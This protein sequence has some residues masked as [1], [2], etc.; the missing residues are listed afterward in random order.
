MEVIL[1]E[2]AEFQLSYFK[3]TNQERI[4]KKIRSLIENII[5]NPYKGI[6]K[7]EALRFKLSGLWSRRINDE[8]RLVYEVDEINNRI[9]IHSLKG[10]YDI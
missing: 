5:E 7:P 2:K 8:H 9:M 10:H 1:F 4:L 6:G 3:K